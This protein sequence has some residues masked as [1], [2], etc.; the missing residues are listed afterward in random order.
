MR[1]RDYWLSFIAP[2]EV[3]IYT[4]RVDV[5]SET[6]YSSIATSQSFS[7]ETIGAGEE[8]SPQIEEYVNI[9]ELTTQESPDYVVN[10]VIL[11][12]AFVVYWYV[13]K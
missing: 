13:I 8:D 1:T 2:S 5:E 6:A 12:I 11:G 7:I 4:Y 10:M 9:A 3:G